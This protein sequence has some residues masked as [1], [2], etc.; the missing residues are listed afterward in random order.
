VF[1]IVHGVGQNGFVGILEDGKYNAEIVA[2]P[3]GVNTPFYWA[4]GNF[5]VRRPYFQPTSKNMG[6]FNTYQ[7][8]KNGDD[9]QLRYLFLS[10]SDADYVGMAKAYRNYMTNNGSLDKKTKDQAQIPLRIVV[11]GA[12]KEKKLIGSRALK[13]TSFEETESMVEQLRAQGIANMEVEVRGWNDGGFHNANPDKFPI[14]SA[15]GGEQ[16][17]LRLQNRMSEL[18]YPLYLYADYT[19]AYGDN[20]NFSPRTDAARKISNEVMKEKYWANGTDENMDVY[21][22]RPDIA[23]DLALKDADRLK[24]LG[25]KGV[26][27]DT[28]GELLYSD[29]RGKSLLGRNQAAKEYV[30]L[31]QGIRSGVGKTAWYRPNDYL[32]PYL[33][34]VFDIP[35]ASSQYMFTTDTVPFLQIVFHGFV[36]YFAPYANYNPNPK[37]YLLQ[38]VEYGAYPSYLLTYEPSWKLKNTLSDYLFTSFFPDWKGDIAAAYKRVNE[39]LSQ[40]QTSAIQDRRV[41]DWG[42]VETVYDNGVRIVVNYRSEDAKVGDRTIPAMDF[43]VWGGKS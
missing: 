34:Q 21:Y 15:I 16:G 36:D 43:A 9:L 38:M 4:G 33:D 7:K 14:E 37:E 18:G 8:E 28:T 23:A 20:G 27:I 5:I 19:I 11:L 2:Y 3:S 30:R 10:G 12:E 32:F 17:L 31:A 29:Y 41:L 42:I 39:A 13:M 40:V 6:G 35:M 22:M 25:V 1:G 26:A 24:R